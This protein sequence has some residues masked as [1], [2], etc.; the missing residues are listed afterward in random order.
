M[1]LKLSQALQ[2]KMCRL[3]SSFTPQLTVQLLS[4]LTYIL[5]IQLPTGLKL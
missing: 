5:K 4:V 3:L 2:L 1:A